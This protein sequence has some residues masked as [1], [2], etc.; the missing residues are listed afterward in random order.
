MGGLS[1]PISGTENRYRYQGHELQTELGLNTYSTFYR[2]YDP[3]IG[4]WWQ[5]DP[6]VESI[7]SYT[8]YSGMLNNP[9]LMND[10]DGDCPPGV[11][12]ENPLP[13][14]E[15]IRVNR[16]SN[17]GPGYIRNSGSRYHKG[18]DL[19]AATGTAVRSGHPNQFST[20][21]NQSTHNTT[22][23]LKVEYNSDGEVFRSTLQK[24]TGANS[25]GPDYTF[26]FK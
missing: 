13:D 1:S 2:E 26:E 6:A 4:R 10:P 18:H 17:L 15:R 11:P 21:N 24:Y 12:C 20:S 3:A 16:S 5:I 19:Y 7:S 25:A 23:V 14:M 9:V 22:S 8:P